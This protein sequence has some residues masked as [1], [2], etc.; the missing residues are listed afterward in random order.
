MRFYCKLPGCESAHTM[1]TKC[2]TKHEVEIEKRAGGKFGVDLLN[3][4][5][6]YYVTKIATGTKYPAYRSGLS[7]GDRI[8][9]INYDD[10]STIANPVAHLRATDSVELT[11]TPRTAL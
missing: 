3:L 11:Y 2:G 1:Y 5:H 9:G 10:M 6:E 7:F 8:D 4:G